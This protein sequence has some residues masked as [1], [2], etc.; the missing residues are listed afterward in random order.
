MNNVEELN[1]EEKEFQT[2]ERKRGS[3]CV[4]ALQDQ[5]IQS[6]ENEEE[7]RKSLG[8]QEGTRPAGEVNHNFE[9]CVW[10]LLPAI[11]HL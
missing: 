5:W 1:P 4:P 8:E 9:T 3:S 6:T 7:T 11:G 10:I 2:E